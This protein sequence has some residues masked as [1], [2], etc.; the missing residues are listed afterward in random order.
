MSP[1]RIAALCLSGFALAA[2]A[3]ASGSTITVTNTGDAQAEDAACTLREAIVAANTN[4]ESGNGVGGAPECVAGQAAPTVDVIAFSIAGAGPHTISPSAAALPAVTEPVTI[5]GST[6]PDEVRLDGVGAPV[7]STGLEVTADDVTIDELTIARFEV[8]VDLSG[9]G[10][11]VLRDSFIGTDPAGTSGLGNSDDGVR[12]GFDDLST[13]GAR[14]RDNVIS[15]NG[16]EGIALRED[17]SQNDVT[18]NRIGTNPGGNGPVANGQEGIE[19]IGAASQNVIGGDQPADQNLISG[20]GSAGV[21]FF[22]S[23]LARASGNSVLG[24]RIGTRVAGE[25]PEPNDGSGVTIGGAVDSTEIRGNLISGND[26]GVDINDSAPQPA[27]EAGPTDTVVAGNLIGTDKDGEAV[28]ANTIAGIDV[29][30]INDRPVRGTVIG[31]TSGLTP[32]GACSGDCN[33]IAGVPVANSTIRIQGPDGTEVLGNH[34][35]TD[36]EGTAGLSNFDDGIEVRDV[37]GVQIGAPGA[38][39][40]IAD[41]GEHG[42]LIVGNSVGTA[43][44]NVVQANTIG[45]GSDGSTALG[46]EKS[47]VF[48]GG[49]ASENLIG[50]SGA[51]EG[52]TIAENLDEGVTLQ[53]DA[54][55]NAIL[56]NSIHSNGDLGI[57]VNND[58]VTFNDPA[59]ADAG[60]NDLQNFPVLDVAVADLQ[61]TGVVGVLDSTPDTSFRIELFA[62]EGDPQGFGEGETFLGGFEVTTDAVGLAPFSEVLGPS[63]AGAEISA[64]ATELGPGGEPLSTSEFGPNS[65]AEPCQPGA[66]SGDDV[67]TGTGPA[68]DIVCGL[69]GDDVFTPDGG[70]NV[71]FGGAGT[72]EIDYSAGTEAIEA[73]LDAGVITRGA[74]TELVVGV[75][76]VTGTDFEDVILGDDAR[77]LRLRRGGRRHGRG[78]RR[79][80][81]PQGLRRRRHAEGRRRRRRAAEPGRGRHAARAGRRRR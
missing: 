39:N 64:T 63:A 17:A 9:S 24:N 71:F 40:V 43:T 48:I 2:P 13:T 72:D 81:H 52:N 31:G 37:T 19:V 46:N 34:I 57:D 65:E 79:G 55:D 41:N 77:Q 59:D 58:T 60:V 54:T 45:L 70:D 20:N 12:L 42:I 6:E 69:G 26:N 15:G 49:F 35:G 51:G 67:L 7:L 8:G 68:N 75:E 76:D 61:G 3:Q 1:R 10:D 47:G 21:R 50:G 38:G 36:L 25:N 56:G 66:T 23:G 32:G 74:G 16:T 30:E 14:V 11:A 53:D 29:T 73:D 27:G 33:L 44:G 4:A 62:D 22:N 5:D 78:P 18:G 80:R 28:V